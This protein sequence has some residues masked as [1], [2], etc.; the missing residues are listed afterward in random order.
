MKALVFHH[1][2]KVVVEQVKD[3]SIEHD[4]DIIVKVT[5]TAICGSDLHIFNGFI[6]Q[7]HE[8]VL[9][10]EFMGIVEETGKEIS[11]LKK[12]IALLS[13]FQLLVGVA[14]SVITNFQHIANIPIKIMAPKVVF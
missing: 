9:G 2:K 7:K 5:S 12:G 8:M 10:H 6:P 3:P 11:H 1:P 4:K 14:F 13:P